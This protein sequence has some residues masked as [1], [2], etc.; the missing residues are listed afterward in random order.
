LR[1]FRAIVSILG[2]LAGCIEPY[3]PP[4]SAAG[5]NPLVVEGGLHGNTGTASVQLTRTARLSDGLPAPPVTGAV[6]LLESRSG[7][8]FALTDPDG[9]GL[10]SRSGLPVA[11]GEEFRLRVQAGGK[12]YVSD[13]EVARPA[14][15][16]D[17][18]S[19]EVKEDGI[20]VYVNTHDT[21]NE[22][23]NYL[24]T[25][26]ETWAYTSA[27]ESTVIF[28]NGAPRLRASSEFV[29]MCY[30]GSVS[31]TINNISTEKLSEN[32]VSKFPLVFHPK[33][34]DKIRI[35]YSILVRQYSIDDE[36]HAFWTQMKKNSQNLGTLFDPL[37]T[38]IT[39]NLHNEN[40]PGE[41]VLGFFRAGY[42]S[43]QRI[44]ISNRD[45]PR[46]FREQKDFG[47]CLETMWPV[48]DIGLFGL[49]PYLITRPVYDGITIIGYNYSTKDCVD[50][51]R[52]GGTT[53][54]PDFW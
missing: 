3:T 39:G 20:Q 10:Y 27:F 11:P 35:R 47:N 30:Q 46:D 7:A 15:P 32:R 1:Y 21:E 50:C 17:S 33:S 12:S 42:S 38:Q 4:E 26:E 41:V 18:V 2:A 31:S 23:G 5:E 52:Q 45:L 9:K 43:E 25:Y 49:Y 51:R 14:P 19:W 48:G 8:S 13:Y 44:F 34:S 16:I 37:P 40:D 29:Y 22:A 6:V 24:W 28:E 36:E 53:T 54:P